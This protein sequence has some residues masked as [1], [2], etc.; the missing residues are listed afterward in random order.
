MTT[1]ALRRNLF[2]RMFGIPMTNAPGQTGCWS[3][4]DGQVTIDLD[5]VPELAQPGGA[6]RLESPDLPV[7]LLVFRDSEGVYRAFCNQCGH[8]GRKLDPVPGREAVQCCSMGKSTFGFD[9]AILS[10]PATKPV[11]TFPVRVTDS[12]LSI[13]VG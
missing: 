2:Q 1:K 7:P 3:C 13:T 10:G 9:G 4:R 11:R 5:R 6:I 8:G 12:T